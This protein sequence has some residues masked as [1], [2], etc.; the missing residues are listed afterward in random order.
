MAY[1]AVIQPFPEPFF[2]PG[3]PASTDAAQSTRVLPNETRH[4]P[5]A[6]GAAPRSSVMGL[7]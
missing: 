5:S 7:S 2:Q 4:D 3:T 1:S 6:N